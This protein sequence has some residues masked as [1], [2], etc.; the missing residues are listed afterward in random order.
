MRQFDVLE[1]LKCDE[2]KKT[3]AIFFLLILGGLMG[4]SSE[5]DLQ[6]GGEINERDSVSSALT[7]SLGETFVNADFIP[8][9]DQCGKRSIEDFRSFMGFDYGND[10]K[11]LTAKLGS[12][13]KGNYST[14]STHFIYYY[15]RIPRVP[16]QAWVHAKSGKLITLFI[17]VLSL[18]SLFNEDLELA[19]AEYGI[20]ECEAKYLGLTAEQIIAKLGEPAEDAISRENVHLLTY[21]SDDFEIAVAFK[22]YPQE[23]K[24]SSIAVNWFYDNH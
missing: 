4:C 3:N 18:K 23:N 14:D 1:L 24:C 6:E 9:I 2:M 11:F 10:E 13:S 5:P 15:D 21:D 19:K 16:V 17:E 12:F 7:D 20:G 8:E 22:I